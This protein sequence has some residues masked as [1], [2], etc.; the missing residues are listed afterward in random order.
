VLRRH[1]VKTPRLVIAA[2]TALAAMLAPPIAAQAQETSPSITWEECPAQVTVDGAEC[3]RVEVP[4][5]Y[6]NPSAGNISVGFVRVKAL[7][8]SA[9]RG[10]LLAYSLVACLARLLLTAPRWVAAL[11]MP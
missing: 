5:Y 1:Y 3:G 6:S 2:A 7:D 11:S 4:T 9:K 8:Q 10:T